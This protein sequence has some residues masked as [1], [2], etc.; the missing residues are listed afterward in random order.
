MTAAGAIMTVCGPIDPS[1][2]GVTLM[3][4]HLVLDG[5]CWLEHAADT[6]AR[7]FAERP[8]TSDIAP[9]IRGALCSNR[10]N[11][12]LRDSSASVSELA[13][14]ASLG[15]RSIVDVTSE[16]LAPDPLALRAIA[17]ASG[18]HV[19]MGCGFYCEIAV[20]QKLVELSVERLAD[21]IESR[22]LDG[23]D[24]VRAGIIGEV[25]VNGQEHTTRRSVGDM[26][27]FEER[28]LRAAARAS[29]ATGAAVTIHMP[30][31]SSAVERVMA[32][33]DNEG[34]SPDRVVLGHMSWVRDFETH[35]RALRRGYWIAYDDFGMNDP[36]WYNGIDDN[37]RIEWAVDVFGHGFGDRLLI[38]QDV[39]CKVTLRRFG[40]TG[41]GHILRSVV[42]AL[43][44]RGLTDSDVEQ[45]LIRN[46]AQ[47]LAF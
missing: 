37:R 32:I 18:I 22:V 36:R 17:E 31:R 4:E 24:G 40:G 30:D 7:A 3:H 47:I 41:Y 2:L 42:P 33:V 11:M 10:D 19:V 13:D 23:V 38:S 9:K 45:L 29:I 44:Q 12:V 8:V 39:A 26:T 28:S 16:G 15:G 43:R 34:V 25:G 27:A 1:D 14:F 46:P 35:L 5:S 20:P 6:D 21:V